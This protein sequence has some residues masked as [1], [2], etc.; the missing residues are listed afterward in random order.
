MGTDTA[1]TLSENLGAGNDIA[2]RALERTGNVGMMWALIIWAVIVVVAVAVLAIKF[3]RTRPKIPLFAGIGGAVL[4][5]V[6]AVCFA[7]GGTGT[8]RAPKTREEMMQAAEAVNISYFKDYSLKYSKKEDYV[9][10]AYKFIGYVRKK[11]SDNTFCIINEEHYGPLYIQ[12]SLEPEDMANVQ[13]G[14]YQD[15]VAEVTDVDGI[16]FMY[17]YLMD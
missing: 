13:E 10:K 11:G 9:G 14:Y 15:F 4:L 2:A 16:F 1:T 3:G 17:G 8:Q 7:L 5:G 6:L 12:L